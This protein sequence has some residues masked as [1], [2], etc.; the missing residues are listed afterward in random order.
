MLTAARGRMDFTVE[1]ISFNEQEGEISLSFTPN[2]ERYEWREVGGERC[3]YDKLDDI[4]IPESVLDDL[5]KQMAGIP[6]RYEPQRIASA[7]EYV[8]GR[9]DEILAMINGDV[10]DRRIADPSG[11][12]LKNQPGMSDFVILSLDV[13]GSTTLATTLEAE[14]YARLMQVAIFELSAVV[15]LFRGHVLKYTGDGLLAY[16]QAPNFIAKND[17]A[18]DCALT[19]RRLVLDGLNPV[20]QSVGY[21]PLAIRVGLDSGEA[22][23]VLIG[24]AETK[25]HSD[26]LGATV[27]VAC[28][29]QGVA[30]L[31]SIALG[32]VTV[33]NLHANWRFRCKE[34][35]PPSPFPYL[36]PQ[37]N[38]PY[39]VHVIT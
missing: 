7:G 24:S 22:A 30:P 12:F 15:P 34:L 35:I 39:V 11:D 17:L 20:L 3:L 27:S 18:I 31:N 16:F 1:V 6:I 26:I 8:H 36:D 33:K 23:V 38:L 10:V 37:T 4:H 21:D 28:K 32:D 19:M 14:R 29:I 9:R 13:A 2:P 25:R 5:V